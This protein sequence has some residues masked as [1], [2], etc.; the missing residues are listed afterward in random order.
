[1]A[2]LARALKELI[3]TVGVYEIDTS[4]DTV[5]STHRLG[6]G[7]GGEPYPSLDGSYIVII[8]KNGGS[9]IRILEVG[10]PGS[11]STVLADLE[12]D[13]K[14]DGDRSYAGHSVARDFAF[15]LK[16]DK[17]Y[18]IIP[19]GT[20]HEISIVDF[21]DN[22]SVKKV[23]LTDKVFENTAP[24][25]RYRSVEW[26]VGTD[27]VWTN[28]SKEDEH[29]VIDFI[30]GKLV[31]TVT[32]I[33][34][35]ELLSVTNW[36]RV[37]EHAEKEVMMTDIQVMQYQAMQEMSQTTLKTVEDLELV[38]ATSQWD[39]IMQEVAAMQQ[40]QEV[41]SSKSSTATTV[42]QESGSS[43]A[44]A[45]LVIGVFALVVGIANL[46]VLNKIKHNNGSS[47]SVGT[48]KVIAT[49]VPAAVSNSGNV[50][51]GDVLL[52]CKIR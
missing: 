42:S 41:L 18:L 24:H 51:V 50:H 19:S 40:G 15:A 11:P 14:I 38:R 20:A 5:V 33:D 45:A 10:A 26:A 30:Q 35:S 3:H 25:G 34:R 36:D 16:D 52:L 49:G 17:T 32:G 1:M 37:R 43:L 12:L 23:V 8:G 31:N 6:E 48:A 13:F 46:Y 44:V 7:I 27:Y 29:Y 21:S 47:D 22:F 28:D 4:T 2:D 9:T 39:S